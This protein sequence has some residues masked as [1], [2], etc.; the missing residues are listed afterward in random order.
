MGDDELKPCNLFRLMDIVM[1]N[2]AMEPWHWQHVEVE[3]FAF[4][5]NAADDNGDEQEYHDL[6]G[7]RWCLIEPRHRQHVAVVKVDVDHCPVHILQLAHLVLY[8]CVFAILF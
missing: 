5:E 6:S 1:G 3:D 2:G 7:G 4:D 8:C